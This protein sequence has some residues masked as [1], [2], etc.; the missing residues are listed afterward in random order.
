LERGGAAG[1]ASSLVREQWRWKSSP[2]PSIEGR[3]SRPG[4][5][6]TLEASRARAGVKVVVERWWWRKERTSE[7]SCDVV[8][9][10]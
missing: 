3:G 10:F 5:L 2:H 9:G 4:G 8:D 7:V 6:V 1:T